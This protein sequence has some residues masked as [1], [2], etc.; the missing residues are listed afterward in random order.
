MTIKSFI[1]DWMPPAVVRA[2][3]S[4]SSSGIRFEGDYATW[5]EAA[6]HCTGYDAEHILAKVLEATLKV[7]CGEAA[8]ERD[9][10]VFDEIEYA[11]PVTAALMWAAAQSGGNL[12]VLDFGGALGSSYFQNRAFLADLPQVRWSVVEQAHYVYAGQEHIQDE[13]LRF[14]SSIENCLTENKPNVVLLSGV[15]QYLSEPNLVVNK[16]CKLG[17]LVIILD[18]LIINHSLADSIHIQNVPASIYEAAYPCRSFS[19]SALLNQFFHA[20]ELRISFPSLDFKALSKINSNFN[21]YILSR[22]FV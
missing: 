4:S 5:D 19:E 11:W 1:K 12:D 8:Y 22:K 20:Y 7:K 14:Y 9:S 17:S 16:L 13:T 15:L 2:L 3:I 18:R 6:A 10:V 21:G